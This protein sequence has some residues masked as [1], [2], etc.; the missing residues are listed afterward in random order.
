MAMFSAL[1]V[2]WRTSVSLPSRRTRSISPLSLRPPSTSLSVFAV[3]YHFNFPV[4]VSPGCAIR[5]A[6]L[7]QWPVVPLSARSRAKYI[8]SCSFTTTNKDIKVTSSTQVIL[9]YQG[10][11]GPVGEPTLFCQILIL[12]SRAIGNGDTMWLWYHSRSLPKC[13]KVYSSVDASNVKTG[14][15]RLEDLVALW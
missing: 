1:W 9:L 13:L 10:L 5:T 7:L 14:E 8:S 3:P 15:L 4:F 2:P 12:G 6:L 11:C